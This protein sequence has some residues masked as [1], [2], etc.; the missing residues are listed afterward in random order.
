[1]FL[2][3]LM[4]REETGML[5]RWYGAQHSLPISKEVSSAAPADVW[6]FRMVHHKFGLITVG[7]S[8]ISLGLRSLLF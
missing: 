8:K 7:P 5:S 2:L 6:H 3:T 4:E 1:M